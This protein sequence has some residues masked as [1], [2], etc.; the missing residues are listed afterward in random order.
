MSIPQRSRTLDPDAVSPLTIPH[1]LQS[2]LQSLY[3]IFPFANSNAPDAENLRGPLNQIVAA[4]EKGTRSTL[5][6][7]SPHSPL[8]LRH[9][10]DEVEIYSPIRSSG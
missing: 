8:S 5:P 9:I 7:H 3:R 2:L 4:L 10:E 1:V 6:N